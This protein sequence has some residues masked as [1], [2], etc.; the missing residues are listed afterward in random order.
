MKTTYLL[1]VHLAGLL[2]VAAAS[3]GE[4]ATGGDA[5]VC[6]VQALTILLAAA[7]VVWRRRPTVG[8]VVA[9]WQSLGLF[10]MSFVVDNL[11]SGHPG[12]VASTVGYVVA[13]AVAIVSGALGLLSN[14]RIAR[15]GSAPKP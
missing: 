10:A 11:R 9:A 15:A 4:G 2:G 7:V 13:L 1:P 5:T 8:L 12:L 3:V 6:L 14:R